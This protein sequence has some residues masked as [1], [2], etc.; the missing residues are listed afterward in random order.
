MRS[1]ARKLPLRRAVV[2]LAVAVAGATA[3]PALASHSDL[4]GEWHLDSLSGRH[5]GQLGPRLDRAQAG[6]P[7]VVG[8]RWG[9]ALR[10][11]SESDYVNAGSHAELQPSTVSVVAWVRSATTPTQVKAVVSQ[12]AAGSCAYSSY[13]LY[14]GGSLDTA[15]LRFYVHTGGGVVKVSPPASNTMWDGQWH[16]VVGTY[17]GAAVRLWVDG[18]QVGSDTPA[19]GPIGYGLDVNNDFIIGGALA[20]ACA[21]KTN[22]TGDVDEV[23]VYNRALSPGEIAYLARSD[24]TTPPELPIPGSPPPAT[25]PWWSRTRSSSHRRCLSPRGRARPPRSAAAARRS[26]TS[27]PPA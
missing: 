12:G 5:A 11:P 2:S 14:T 4:G 23:R 6:S 17:D 1:A 27:S 8:G 10:F 3:Q 15:G 19:S 21:S 22:F 26:P 18:Q 7:Q 24:H 20:P 25:T 16:A 9:N 13:S